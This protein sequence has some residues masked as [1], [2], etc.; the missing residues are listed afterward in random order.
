MAKPVGDNDD[1]HD[2][3]WRATTKLPLDYEPYGQ[4]DRNG[5]WDCSCGCRYF[6]PLDGKLRFDWG[7]CTNPQSHRCGL[8]TFEHMGCPQFEPEVDEADQKSE[9][10]ARQE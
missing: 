4:T 10:D 5:Y 9:A 8:L 7:V 6:V 1:L 3:L 2:Q